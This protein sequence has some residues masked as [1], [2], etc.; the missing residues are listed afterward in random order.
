MLNAQEMHTTLCM[1]S[2]AK[3]RR[4]SLFWRKWVWEGEAFGPSGPPVLGREVTLPT[5]L[6]GPLA[7]S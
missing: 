3:V 4:H 6:R 5:S 2:V 1:R 7:N